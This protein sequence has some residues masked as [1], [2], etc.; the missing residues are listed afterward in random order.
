MKTVS[1]QNSPTLDQ[2]DHV[3]KA[4]NWDLN[5]E[6]PTTFH[7]YILFENLHTPAL[8]QWTYSRGAEGSKAQ[9][10]KHKLEQNSPSVKAIQ[11]FGE[12]H[13]KHTLD[14]M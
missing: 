2:Q 9:K 5:R 7:V 3:L 14:P 1:L 10:V 4:C 12:R 8:S 13:M 11:E 6:F